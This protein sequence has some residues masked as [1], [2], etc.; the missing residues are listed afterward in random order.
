MVSHTVDASSSVTLVNCCNGL[1]LLVVYSA[2]SSTFMPRLGTVIDSFNHV[3]RQSCLTRYDARPRA[4][5][6][7][8]FSVCFLPHFFLTPRYPTATITLPIS[9]ILC[10]RPGTFV[11]FRLAMP[12]NTL[13]PVSGSHAAL[14]LSFFLVFSSSRV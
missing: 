14:C 1:I 7:I 9:Y 3:L 13:A 4:T 12:Y 2:I 6:S 8:L 11:E 10:Q 5:F